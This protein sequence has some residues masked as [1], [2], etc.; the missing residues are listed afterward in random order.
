MR[1]ITITK[2][3]GFCFGV[4][5]ALHLAHQTTKS[6]Q[7]IYI[8]GD[9]VHNPRVVSDIKKTGIKKI[10]R[11]LP[12]SDAV[13]LIRA[14]GATK[15]VYKKAKKLGFKI[16][17]ATCPMVKEIHSTSLKKNIPR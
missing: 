16:I 12:K 4:R 5:R 10:H 2:S 14:H 17:D 11:L 6:H 13:L 15:S 8:L 7:N 3:A 1:K 9:I